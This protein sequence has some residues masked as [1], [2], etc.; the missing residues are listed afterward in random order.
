[1]F[2]LAF[3]MVILA[4]LLAVICRNIPIAQL[5]GG[6]IIPIL[7]QVSG[8]QIPFPRISIFWQWLYYISPFHYALSGLVL[9]QF[10]CEGCREVVQTLSE[11]LNT[12]CPLTCP[13]IQLSINQTVYLSDVILYQFAYTRNNLIFDM[14]MLAVFSIAMY[15]TKTILSYFIDH[16][17]R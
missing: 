15:F 5:I 17:R 6:L 14:I 8:L 13:K 3:Y 4:Q 16:T 10:Y 1:M 11:V 9:S 12:T 2:E 7:I